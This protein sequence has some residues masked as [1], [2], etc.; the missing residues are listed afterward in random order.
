MNMKTGHTDRNLSKY[1]HPQEGK[2]NALRLIPLGTRA[3]LVTVSGK[4]QAPGMEAL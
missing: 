4:L 1:L 2:P 3:G